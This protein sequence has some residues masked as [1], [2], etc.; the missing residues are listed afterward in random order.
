MAQ[1][2]SD[3]SFTSHWLT[4]GL[5]AC[6]ATV[7]LLMLVPVFTALSAGIAAVS[8]LVFAVPLAL[9]ITL[10]STQQTKSWQH[11]L[12]IILC[13]TGLLI[14]Q[15]CYVYTAL[16]HGVSFNFSP[17]SYAHFS[18]TT[19]LSPSKTVYYLS[20]TDQPMPIAV[21]PSSTT[22]PRPTVVLVHGGGWRYGNHQETGE[23]PQVLSAAGYTVLSVE[24]TLSS[25][26]H[27]T[28]DKSPD[29]IHRAMEYITKHA[30]ELAVNPSAI[31]LLGQSAGG[32]LALL[33]AYTSSTPP[34]SVISLYAPTDLALDYAT[35]RDKSAEIN[36]LG[37]TPNEFPIRYRDLSPNNRVL[38]SSPRTLV[39]QGTTDDLVTAKS[40][41]VL[42]KALQKQ[43]VEHSLV[44]LPLTGHSFENQTGG[45]A[46][47]IAQQSVLKFLN[48]N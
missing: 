16:K 29:D 42:T 30:K 25:P 33:E 9:A 35:S 7:L 8:L 13:M 34:A 3:N 20:K 4:L 19:A 27:P 15:V 39:I 2:S 22:G 5:L 44:I 10:P 17:L 6:S 23:W 46:T 12:T 45:F 41:H 32:H 36:F 14:P 40:A 21:Y 28:W 26:G 38:P 18:G 24:Y 11:K 48:K 1:R 47:Q 31:N 43:G 37:G